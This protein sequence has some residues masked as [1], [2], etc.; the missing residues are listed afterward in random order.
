VLRSALLTLASNAALSVPLVFALGFVGP[1]LATALSFIPMA[2]VY[3]LY[4]AKAAGV[5]LGETFP[6]GGYLRVV[7]A[8]ALPA[9]AAVVFKLTVE[10]HPALMF[11]AIAGIV[12]LGW[13]VVGTLFRLIEADDWAFVRR[14]LRLGVFR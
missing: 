6:L 8:A 9:T 11:V 7:G 3:N 13:A 1:A 2:I 14:W 5:R 12:L 10:L 4:I